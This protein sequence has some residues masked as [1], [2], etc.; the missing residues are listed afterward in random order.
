MSVIWILYIV[1]IIVGIAFIVLFPIFFWPKKTV[2]YVNANTLQNGYDNGDGTIDVEGATKPFAVNIN[3]DGIRYNAATFSNATGAIDSFFNRVVGNTFTLKSPCKITTLQIIADFLNVN[4]AD[5]TRQVAIYDM[6]TSEMLVSAAVGI[7]DPVIDGFYTHQLPLANQITLEFDH[8]YAIVAEVRSDDFYSR[9]LSF[10]Q[11]PPVVTLHQRASIVAPSITLP[12]ADQFSH[13]DPNNLQ[14]AS[15]QYVTLVVNQTAFQVDVR[16]Q[17]ASFPLNYIYNLNVKCN[18]STV[19]LE[20]GLCTSD[21]QNNNMLNNSTGNLVISPEVVGVPNGLDKDAVAAD[22]WYA[23]F[24]ITSSTQGLPPA[25]LLSLNQ[26]LPSYLPIGYESTKRVG[27]ARTT[28][29]NASQFYRTVQ[30]GNGTRRQTIYLAPLP[31]LVTRTFAVSEIDDQK[32]V[33][34]PLSLVSPTSSSVLLQITVQNFNM[35]PIQVFFKEPDNDFALAQVSANPFD[36][37]VLSVEFPI[38]NF[39][40]PHQL[41]IALGTSFFVS[42]DTPITIAVQSFFDDL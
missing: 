39:Y 24:L 4:A 30:N 2:T 27:W 21:A 34:I 33:T 15:F 25:G 20:P 6:V 41:Q 26:Q 16:S 18:T 31:I 12:Q 32:Y 10:V 7:T 35:S 1:F 23:V 13:D 42:N 3:Q 40:S 22:Q 28:N 29:D 9:E 37:S 36:T 19:E 8:E 17:N 14:F 5:S 11:T 38:S